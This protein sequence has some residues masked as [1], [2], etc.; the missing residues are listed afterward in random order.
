MTSSNNFIP[1]SLSQID[2]IKTRL[3]ECK[4]EWLEVKP[5]RGGGNYISHNTIRQI[6][7]NAV[8]GITYWDFGITEQWKEEVY[9]FNKDTNQWGFDGYVYHVKGYMYIP[10]I[11]RREQYGCKTGVGGINNQEQAYKAAA[12]N[13]FAKC[14][15]LFGVGEEIYSKIIVESNDQT[16]QQ[17]QQNYQQQQ[18]S[19]QQ[20]QQYQQQYSQ[21]EY[22]QQQ[23]QQNYNYNNQQ[24][25]TQNFNQQGFGQPY[26]QQQVSDMFQGVPQVND[27]ELPFNQ[28]P[29]QAIEKQEASFNGHEAEV[30][31]VEAGE[32]QVFG[33][34]VETSTEQEH[35]NVEPEEVLGQNNPWENSSTIKDLQ[36]Y[37]SHKARLGIES[38]EMMTPHL[39]DFFKDENANLSYITPKNLKDLNKHLESITI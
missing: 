30:K 25:N 18:Q 38:D 2:E 5:G 16:E 14:A 39:R 24:Q 19:Y 3:R 22:G 36:E 32:I 33:A 13:C 17:Q 31:D 8:R 10:G 34:P 28:A 12:S 4:D 1:T 23:Q 29:V 35:K 11:G 15:S 21:Q 37:S 20:G 6:L 26:Q 27:D 9:S 7:D